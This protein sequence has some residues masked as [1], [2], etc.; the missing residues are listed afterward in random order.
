MNCVVHGVTKSD[1]T[2][3]LSHSHT[4]SMWSLHL[5]WASQ[6]MQA[7]LEETSAEVASPIKAQAWCPEY[8]FHCILL[9]KSI[10]S[11]SKSTNFWGHLWR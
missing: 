10:H 9:I 2:E 8:Y 6:S 7:G 5:A 3:Q 11:F 1:T 4:Y